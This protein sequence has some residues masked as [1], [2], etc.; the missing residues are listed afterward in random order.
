MVGDR[1]RDACEVPEDG[2]VLR[3]REIEARH[4]DGE[5]DL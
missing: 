4:E 2:L 3:E 5:D 1:V